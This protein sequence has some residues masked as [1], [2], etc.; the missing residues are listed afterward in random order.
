MINCYKI[1]DEKF[2]GVYISL[3]FMTKIED[4][5]LSKNA[6][7]SSMLSK[8][9]KKYKNEEEIGKYLASL[10]GANFNVNIE[11]YGDI[12]NIEFKML[13]IN[14]SVIDA[15]ERI[16]LKCLEFLNDMIFDS[17]INDSDFDEE[18]F[19]REKEFIIEKINARKDEK[20]KY[21]VNRTE[22]LMCQNKGFG[23]YI[24]GES[25]EVKSLTKQDIIDAYNK[26]INNSVINIV[27]SGNLKDYDDIDIKI[28]DIFKDNYNLGKDI[29]SL[30]YNEISLLDENKE[31]IENCDSTQSVIGAGF[32]IENTTESDNAK[33]NMYNAILGSTPSSKLFQIFREKES[34]AYTTRS[35]FYRFKNMIVIYA[36][37]EGKNYDK[38]KEVILRI[39][40]SIENGDITDEEFNAAKQSLIADLDEWVDSKAMQAKFLLTD[41]V[42][43]KK[44]N[45]TVEDIKNEI[46]KVTKEDVVEI[47]KKVKLKLWYFLGGETHE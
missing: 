10:Y 15:K 44:F 3:N 34:L 45:R 28:K 12:E 40:K 24:Y 38:S 43:Y 9:N 16:I 8:S 29:E 18:L 23:K 22:E 36:G 7:L 17:N 27:L 19:A 2:K 11:K 20:L 30:N 47:A 25:E 32:I 37:I 35:R 6:V 39:M 5:N 41:L 21:G 26:L 14:E 46:N 31:I 4:N 42:V 33:I 1:N 13:S